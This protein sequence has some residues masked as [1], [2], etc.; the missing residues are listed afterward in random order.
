MASPARSPQQE[1][2]SGKQALL[3]TGRR[4]ATGIAA[5]LQGDPSR[6]SDTNLEALLSPVFP[7]KV[8]SKTGPCSRAFGNQF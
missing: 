7:E 8:A 6:G 2:G 3:G 4:G 1:R 5:G